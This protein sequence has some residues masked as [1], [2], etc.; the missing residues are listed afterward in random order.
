VTISDGAHQRG[1]NERVSEIVHA[2]TM[3]CDLAGRP[4]QP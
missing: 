4:D 3:P 2:C 1:A